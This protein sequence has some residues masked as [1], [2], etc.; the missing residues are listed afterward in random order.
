MADATGEDNGPGEDLPDLL[1]QREGAH[2]AGMAA[3]TRGHADHAIDAG[4][5][6]LLRMAPV[7]DVVKDQPAVGLHRLHHVRD[8]AQRGND[9]R[10]PVLHH[11]L[12]IGLKP[13]IAAVNDEVDAE[14]RGRLSFEPLSNLMQPRDEAVGGALIEGR[15]AADDAGLAGLDDEVRTGGQEH[16][17][18]NRRDR[19]AACEGAR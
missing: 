16:R 17:G 9:Q 5:R 19:Q 13:R 1:H 10:H 11:L 18:G 3:S 4:L 14:G 6:R 2:D 12:Q 15:E 7:D 8:G